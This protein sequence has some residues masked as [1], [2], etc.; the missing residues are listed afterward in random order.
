MI[1]KVMRPLGGRA[2]SIPWLIY[3]QGHKHMQRI[4]PTPRL[5]REFGGEET[6]YYEAD[7]IKGKFSLIRRVEEQPW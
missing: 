2:G 1:V 4:A 3:A 7:L 6:R 5:I